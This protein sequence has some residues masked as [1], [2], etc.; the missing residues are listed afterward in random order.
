MPA[1]PPPRF[2]ASLLVPVALLLSLALSCAAEV[3][4]EKLFLQ[5]RSSDYEEQVE[6][7]QKLEE[8][9]TG[10]K[11]GVFA[12]GLRSENSEI[13]VE[14]LA[15]K[16]TDIV[17][18]LHKPSDTDFMWHR[19]GGLRSA[20][21]ESTP[22]GVDEFVFVDAYEG[23]WQECFPNG[24]QSVA[25]KGTQLPFHGELLA[26]PFGVE[27][28]EDTPE[29]VSVRLSAETMRTPFRLVFDVFR[30]TRAAVVAIWEETMKGAGVT[31]SVTQPPRP[32]EPKP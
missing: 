13:R 20:P 29:V 25:Y 4:V 32:P 15:D 11:V 10:G 31:V 14:V 19:P 8:L 23:G 1:L 27:V 3:E 17:S 28:L 21:L 9:V 16:G 26:A 6:A 18:F 24:G 5:S 2:P 30:E 12:R 22:R 7:R